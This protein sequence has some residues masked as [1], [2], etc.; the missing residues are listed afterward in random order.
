VDNPEM[1]AQTYHELS[2]VVK[3]LDDFIRSARYGKNRGGMIPPSDILRVVRG[4]NDAAAT[5][6]GILEGAAVKKISL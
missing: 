4:V 5:M 2:E 3:Q 1:S 6:N